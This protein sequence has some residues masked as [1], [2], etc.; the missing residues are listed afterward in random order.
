MIKSLCSIILLTVTAFFTLSCS[1]EDDK[2]VIIDQCKDIERMAEC[3]QCCEAEGFYHG[4][5]SNHT[6]AC[7]CWNED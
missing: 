3:R 5:P 4:S 7:E 2:F 6:N 1:S